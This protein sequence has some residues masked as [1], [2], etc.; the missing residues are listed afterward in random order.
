MV[1]AAVMMPDRI[2][3]VKTWP[4][5]CLNAAARLAVIS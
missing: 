1:H 2:A 4:Y 5:A 3:I